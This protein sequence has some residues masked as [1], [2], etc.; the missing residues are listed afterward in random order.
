V[1]H[2]LFAL[3]HDD[4]AKLRDEAVLRAALSDLGVDADAVFDEI[5]AGKPLLQ[6]KAEHT[7][8]VQQANVW[9][10]PTFIVGDQAA[11][12]RLMHRPDGDGAEARRT[13]DRVLDL[14]AWPDLNEFKHTSIPR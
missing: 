10:V 5:G 3:R 2:R 14:L 8:A 12:V 13:I 1:H 11:F 9:G 6:V 4:G 7:D